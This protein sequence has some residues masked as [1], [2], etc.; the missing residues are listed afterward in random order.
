MKFLIFFMEEEAEA[1]SAGVG[2]CCDKA[3]LALPISPTSLG[4]SYLPPAGFLGAQAFSCFRLRQD[5]KGSI[6]TKIPVGSGALPGESNLYPAVST[7]D[8]S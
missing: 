3:L 6:S 2:E 7:S 8:S 1:R 4:N 5:P